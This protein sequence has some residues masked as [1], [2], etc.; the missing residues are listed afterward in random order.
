MGVE[1]GG[2]TVADGD[3]ALHIVF[4]HSVDLAHAKT[5]RK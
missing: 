1:I 5:E 4:A 3:K 2:D